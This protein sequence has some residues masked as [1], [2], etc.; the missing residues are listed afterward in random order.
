MR[1]RFLETCASLPDCSNFHFLSEFV[2]GYIRVDRHCRT[3]A[4][5]GI[6]SLE[7]VSRTSCRLPVF[8]KDKA[9]LCLPLSEITKIVLAKETFYK[10]AVG[11]QNRTERCSENIQFIRDLY[12]NLTTNQG[13]FSRYTNIYHQSLCSALLTSK[14]DFGYENMQ[15]NIIGVNQPVHPSSLI[16]TFIIRCLDSMIS[17]VSM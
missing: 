5:N 11:M 4:R 2:R 12:R 16:N 14:V 1:P 15:T 10:S 9:G 7:S 6:K 8:L 3:L 17:I 13:R